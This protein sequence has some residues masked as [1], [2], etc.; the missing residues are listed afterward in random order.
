MTAHPDD[1]FTP[2]LKRCPFCGGLAEHIFDYRLKDKP[3]MFSTG[4]AAGCATS[5]QFEKPR[6]AARWWNDRHAAGAGDHARI[7]RMEMSTAGV[8]CD[9]E[10]GSDEDDAEDIL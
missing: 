9:D 1:P 10:S 7:L 2:K 5:P 8:P 4:C 3:Q 6:D